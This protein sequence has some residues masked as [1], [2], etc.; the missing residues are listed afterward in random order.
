M[1]FW[2]RGEGWGMQ[3]DDGYAPTMV[4]P[5]SHEKAEVSRRIHY[6]TEIIDFRARRESR[7]YKPGW[8]MWRS[9]QAHRNP[10]LLSVR[11]ALAPLIRKFH[12]SHAAGVAN[13]ASALVWEI[14]CSLAICELLGCAYVAVTLLV[15]IRGCQRRC[16]I[17]LARMRTG[18][19]PAQGLPPRT[20]VRAA[21]SQHPPCVIA[22]RSPREAKVR[23]TSQLQLRNSLEIIL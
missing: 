3:E 17:Y 15:C 22:P 14:L 9:N 6:A 12:Q 13:V 5:C 19:S 18:R 2:P 11:K 20:I 7:M 8:P 21:A 23:S 4:A 16:G 1:H 10:E